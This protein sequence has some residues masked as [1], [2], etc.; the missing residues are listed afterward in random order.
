MKKL[1]AS[2]ALIAL[3]TLGMGAAQAQTQPEPTGP[4]P[5]APVAA[6]PGSVISPDGVSQIEQ[7]IQKQ[8]AHIDGDVKSGK[9]TAK[10]ADRDEKAIQRVSAKLSRDE[11]KH[12]GAITKREQVRL[13][14][15]LGHNRGRIAHQRM[16]DQAASSP[17]VTP[18]PVAQ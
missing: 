14:K 17:M 4:M 13:N 15:M 3:L 11:A 1:I 8:Q 18:A 9:I 10:Q 7:R 12:G 16:K 5:T 6:T 2:T